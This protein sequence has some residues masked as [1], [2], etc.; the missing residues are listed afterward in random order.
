MVSSRNPFSEIVV[1]RKTS[2]IFTRNNIIAP[3]EKL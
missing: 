3:F 2:L 1:G